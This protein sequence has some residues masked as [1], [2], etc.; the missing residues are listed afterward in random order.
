LKQQRQDFDPVTARHWI[1]QQ[2]TD[3]HRLFRHNRQ[4][5]RD[6]LQALLTPLPG[7][8]DHRLIFTREGDGYV[9]RGAA[10]L[11]K[12]LN[13]AV[14]TVWRPHG[15]RPGVF[16]RTARGVKEFLGALSRI[17]WPGTLY[18]VRTCAFRSSSQL[19]VT[20]S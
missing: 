19:R 15:T 14:G 12:I 4:E 2:L 7:S 6:V 3:W 9:F 1:D 8:T 10:T 16:R 11:G 20:W 18:L 13:G 5:S 17:L